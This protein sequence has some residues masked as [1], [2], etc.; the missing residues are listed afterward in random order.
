[1]YLIEVL[2]LENF[3]ARNIPVPYLTLS[4]GIN[5]GNYKNDDTVVVGPQV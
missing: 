5:T 1:M 4:P 2:I 3:L